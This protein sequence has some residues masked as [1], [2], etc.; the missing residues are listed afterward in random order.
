MRQ[1]RTLT[2]KRETLTQLTTDEMATVA[3]G[4]HVC[5]VTDACTDGVTHGPSIDVNCPTLPINPCL[6]PVGVTFGDICA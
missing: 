3:G 4:S 5:G 6:A 1:A 2:L